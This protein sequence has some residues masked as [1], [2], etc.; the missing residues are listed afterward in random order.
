M[1]LLDLELSVQQRLNDLPYPAYLLSMSV[2]ARRLGEI[3]ADALPEDGRLLAA[4]TAAAPRGPICW[5]RPPRM[6]RCSLTGDGWN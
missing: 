5:A 3:Y 1:R 2:I 4:Q 6:R